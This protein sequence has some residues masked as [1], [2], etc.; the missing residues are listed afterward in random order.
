MTRLLMYEP[1]YRRIALRL[2]GLSGLTIV[3]MDKD[4]RFHVGGQEV[5]VDDA[6]PELAWVNT[7][8]FAGPIRNYMLAILKSPDLRWLQSGAAGHDN[9]IFAQIVAKGARLTTNHSQAIAIAEY[10][11]A[12]VLDHF[13]HGPK[14]RAEQA[15]KR[16]TRVLFREVMGTRWLVIGFGAIGQETARRARAFGAHVTGVRRSSGPHPLADALI[17]P[18]EI[19]SVLPQS[20]VVALTLPLTPETKDLVDAR[21]LAAMKPHS[22]LVNV[23]RGGLIDEDA[24]LAALERGTPEHAILDVFQTEP[25]PVES[26]FWGHP[27]VSL[28]AHTS[29][30]GSGLGARTDDLFIENLTRYLAGK[31]LLNEANPNDVRGS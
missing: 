31:P 13:Q 22:V 17:V 3:L 25:L 16:W 12:S 19:A 8:I 23:G 2:E 26:P 14:R 5:S 29:A 15:A 10:I 4:S 28:S 11:V 24:L 6:R 18:S 20:D 21:F 1:S 9:P 27:R 7:D 30:W